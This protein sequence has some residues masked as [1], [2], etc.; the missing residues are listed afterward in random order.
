MS[1]KVWVRLDGPSYYKEFAW[2]PAVPRVGDAIVLLE[3]GGWSETVTSVT[4]DESGVEVHCGHH[5]DKLGEGLADNL[6]A[7]GWQT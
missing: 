4:W 2:W 3:D 7:E 6:L 5:Q 1:V